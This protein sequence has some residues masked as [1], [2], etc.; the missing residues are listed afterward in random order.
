MINH[1]LISYIMQDKPSTQVFPG[2]FYQ[3]VQSH[4]LGRFIV[5]TTEYKDECPAVK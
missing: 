4:R 2:E 5:W 1:K 3:S